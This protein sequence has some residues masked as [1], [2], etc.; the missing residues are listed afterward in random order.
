MTITTVLSALGG[1]LIFYVAAFAVFAIY[2]EMKT[3]RR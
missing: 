1:L 3:R 2:H